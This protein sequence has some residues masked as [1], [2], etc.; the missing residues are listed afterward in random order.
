MTAGMAILD[1]VQQGRTCS[2]TMDLIGE[3]CK[4]RQIN[5]YYY[6]KTTWILPLGFVDDLNRFAK[7]GPESPN[8][9]TS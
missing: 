4:D 6:K 1:I 3:K 5:S 8:I 2:N 7:C 9:N